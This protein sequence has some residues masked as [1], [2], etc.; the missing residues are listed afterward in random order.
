[1]IKRTSADDKVKVTFS[2]PYAEDQGAVAVVGDFNQ[3][4]PTANKLV[5]R[6]NGTCST[7]ITL[8]AG[9]TYRFR[10]YGEN[11]SWLNDETADS[12]E[13]NEY[14]SENSVLVL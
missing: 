11:G 3:W 7:T 1:M 5:K 10:Y 13:Q 8:P 9:N 14:G 4:N 12:V 2:L 6:N